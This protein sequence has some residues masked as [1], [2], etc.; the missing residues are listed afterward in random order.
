MADQ[1]EELKQQV[2]EKTAENAK[3]ITE[4]AS[5]KEKVAELTEKLKAA[6]EGLGADKAKELLGNVVGGSDAAEDDGSKVPDK[7]AVAEV[8]KDPVGALTGKIGGLP[9]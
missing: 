8:A 7:E 5:L 4:C 3:L 6:A 2:A 9:F 1:V